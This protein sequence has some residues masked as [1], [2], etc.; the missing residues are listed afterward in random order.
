MQDEDF[1]K[2][3]WTE[4]SP[5]TPTKEQLIKLPRA[6][7]HSKPCCL[8]YGIGRGAHEILYH[9]NFFCGN[10]DAYVE[11]M[12]HSSWKEPIKKDSIVFMCQADHKSHIFPT[13]KEFDQMHHMLLQHFKEVKEEDGDDIKVLLPPLVTVVTASGAT[14][15]AT[16]TATS[17]PPRRQA[18]N[19]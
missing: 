6:R 9:N 19:L 12:I 8:H 4:P 11:A 13:A 7:R 18:P 10:C 14:A 15:T 2:R 16:A 5:P 3:I 17:T 1:Q